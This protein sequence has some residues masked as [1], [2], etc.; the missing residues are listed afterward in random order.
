MKKYFAFILPWY[1]LSPLAL[2]AVRKKQSAEAVGSA[3]SDP[4]SAGACSGAGSG[5]G[6]APAPAPKT[7]QEIIVAVLRTCSSRPPSRGPFIWQLR[8]IILLYN[9]A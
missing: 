9:S 4:G 7:G 6:K 5:A 3:D 8:S 2:S 1:S